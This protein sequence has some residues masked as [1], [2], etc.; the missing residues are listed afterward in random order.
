M[1]ATGKV[2]ANVVVQ[3]EERRGQS[4]REST[5]ICFLYHKR[6]LKN[7]PDWDWNI[8]EYPGIFLRL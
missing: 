4:Y 5:L 1:Q 7:E 6:T 3:V 8:L 2:I